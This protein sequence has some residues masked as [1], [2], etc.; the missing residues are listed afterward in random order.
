MLSAA[1]CAVG[2][3]LDVIGHANFGGNLSGSC[4]PVCRSITLR[5]GSKMDLS[6]LLRIPSKKGKV[7]AG[8]E[9][10]LLILLGINLSGR[11]T[12][13]SEPTC[14]IVTITARRTRKR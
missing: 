13:R 7:Q 10:G 11:A 3:E 2:V 6:K 1:A 5:D 9:P 8:S 14:R 4:L 12:A